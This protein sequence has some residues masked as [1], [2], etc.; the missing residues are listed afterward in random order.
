MRKVELLPTWD[1]E[2]GYMALG[3][4]CGSLYIYC[5]ILILSLIEEFVDYPTKSQFWEN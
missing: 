1:C 5:F 2:A 4:D 3:T